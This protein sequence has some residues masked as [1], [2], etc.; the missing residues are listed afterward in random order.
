ML[1]CE[2]EG[3]CFFSTDNKIGDEARCLIKALKSN[4]T[5]TKL[6][7]NRKVVFTQPNH[8]FY[9]R[10]L[11]P[12]NNISDNIIS[13]IKKEIRK[14]QISAKEKEKRAQLIQTKLVNIVLDKI[15]FLSI[16][17]LFFRVTLER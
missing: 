6:N 17:Y 8:A 9:F 3:V 15:N 4:S 13:M 14:N 12:E 11:K 5:I 1:L 10:V 16:V 7:L 2:N